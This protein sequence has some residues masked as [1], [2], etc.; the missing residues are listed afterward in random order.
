VGISQRL[1]KLGH[2]GLNPVKRY[3]KEHTIPHSMTLEFREVTEKNFDEFIGLEV[4]Q[5]QG[6]NFFFKSTRPNL[7]TLA[8]GYIYNPHTKVLAVYDG[9]TMVGS[10][11]YSPRA[12]PP[13]RAR[14]AWLI[15]FMIDKRYQ[16]RGL[17]KRAMELLF[18]RIK[19]ENGGERVRS[20][21]PTSRTT[22]SRRPFTGAWAS[23]R[24]GRGWRAR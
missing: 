2:G 6:D 19:A 9:K 16:G 3:F 12:G 17:G 15:R 21:S 13:G 14:K 20:G 10:V 7:M 4:K 11:F 22:R 24:A 18:E 23:S 5:D 8:Q 1:K